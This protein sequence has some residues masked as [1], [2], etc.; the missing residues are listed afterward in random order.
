[1]A[2]L[3][4][5]RQV[6][7]EAYKILL[8]TKETENTEDRIT[9]LHILAAV[10]SGNGKDVY[11][12][13]AEN[14]HQPVPERS[15]TVH[16]NY[17]GKKIERLQYK[18]QENTVELTFTPFTGEL[19]PQDIQIDY[20]PFDIDVLI[21]IGIKDRSDLP[22]DVEAHQFD[23]NRIKTVNID[24]QRDNTMWGSL[25]IL[26]HDFPLYSLQIVEVLEEIGYDVPRHWKQL[27]MVETKKRIPQ[28]GNATP[29]LLRLV[30]DLAE[31]PES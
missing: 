14:E 30:A 16:F 29:R 20:R 6:I 24:N 9:A 11:L 5:V 1:M 8:V 31:S 3:E 15:A 4:Q 28:V 22:S 17:H 12:S 18:I 26:M 7:G 2:D 27:A 13:P 25:N 21:A 19:S 23:F 10:M